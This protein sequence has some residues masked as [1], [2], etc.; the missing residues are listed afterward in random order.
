MTEPRRS[1]RVAGWLW[2]LVIAAGMV[3]FAVRAT[4]PRLALVANLF[5]GVC[6][7]GVT[8]LL[9][10]LLKPVNQSVAL[11]A[12][13]C[14]LVGVASGAGDA[15]D[16]GQGQGFSIAMVHFGFQI[17][18]VGYLIVRS[19]F[20]PQ[21]LGVLLAIGGSSY[22]ISS[23]ANLLSPAFGAHLSPFIIPIAVL[24]EGSLTVWLIVKG[25]DASKWEGYIRS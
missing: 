13:F 6:Y 7:I 2:L 18:S 5:A 15:L 14:G 1:A 24:G 20:L 11:F 9:Y 19:T 12:A 16:N 17:A 22:V 10:E 23:F 3:A 21:I 4:Q 8:G 25:V